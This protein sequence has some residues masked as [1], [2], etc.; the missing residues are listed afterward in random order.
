M[1]TSMVTSKV[2]IIKMK[3]IGT[4]AVYLEKAFPNFINMVKGHWCGNSK[5]LE[6]IKFF[7]RK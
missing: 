3:I 6:E 1:L 7:F 2:E 5:R 4:E